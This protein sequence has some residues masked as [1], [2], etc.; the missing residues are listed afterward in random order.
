MKQTLQLLKLELFTRFT[1]PLPWEG[2]QNGVAGN[3]CF[4]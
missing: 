2:T 1:E 3:L 4:R